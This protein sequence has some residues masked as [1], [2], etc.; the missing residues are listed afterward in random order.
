MATCPRLSRRGTTPVIHMEVR[1]TEKLATNTAMDVKA[2]MSR[3]MSVICLSL[4]SMFQFCSFFVPLSTAIP[5]FLNEG[6]AEGFYEGMA[7]C[8]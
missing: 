8:G 3:I 5:I 7:P 6:V 4:L 1:I 2:A